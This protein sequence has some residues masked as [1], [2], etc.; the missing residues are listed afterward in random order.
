[1]SS[2]RVAIVLFSGGLDST[3]ALW[4]ALKKNFYVI[5]LM[6]DTGSRVEGERKYAITIL[7][8]AGVKNFINVNLDFVKDLFDLSLNGIIP[9][10]LNTVRSPA[11]IPAKNLMFY[12]IAT[13][14]AEIYN[15]KYIIGGH[16]ADDSNYFLDA[17]PRF[18]R[19]LNKII[20]MGTFAKSKIKI[21]QPL[22]KLSKADVVKMGAK[23]GAPLD[24]T[25][26]CQKNGDIQ[27][28][29]CGACELRRKAFRDANIPD[30]TKYR[31][32]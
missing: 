15:A 5:P 3:V 20:N 29:V 28:G 10:D 1:M 11:Y 7:N 17:T 27:C 30:L 25:W 16:N 8:M 31:I 24:I 19:F 9:Y 32:Y 13:Y 4:W 14:Y 12:S 18:F 21:V 26:S 2:K 6:I 22:I 23:L